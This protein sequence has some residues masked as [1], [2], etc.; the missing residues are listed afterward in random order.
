MSE[1]EEGSFDLSSAIFPSTSSAPSAD[2]FVRS[3]WAKT[4][5]SA[6]LH[7]VQLIVYGGHEVPWHPRSHP[8]ISCMRP[9]LL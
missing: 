4:S 9:S 2:P 5:L 6:I 7:Q 3:K 1:A 8:G